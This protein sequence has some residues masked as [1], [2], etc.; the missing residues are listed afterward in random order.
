MR[1]DENKKNP[2]ETIMRGFCHVLFN[3]LIRLTN[4]KREPNYLAMAFF[5]TGTLPSI[6]REYGHT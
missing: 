5:L 6:A 2:R 1:K 4:L 3:N